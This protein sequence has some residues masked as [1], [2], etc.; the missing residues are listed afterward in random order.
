VQLKTHPIE[1]PEPLED[2]INK[3]D[4]VFF[5]LS[6]FL[7]ETKFNCGAGPEK[8]KKHFDKLATD[9]RLKNAR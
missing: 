4:L 1:L 5:W 3:R 2:G 9:R 7:Y 8:R 6:H